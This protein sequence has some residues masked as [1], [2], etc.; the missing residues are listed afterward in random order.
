LAGIHI[1]DEMVPERCSLYCPTLYIDIV[2][3]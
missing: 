1:T 3:S 2:G